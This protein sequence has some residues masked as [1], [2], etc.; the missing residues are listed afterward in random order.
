M[1]GDR[2]WQCRWARTNRIC[3]KAGDAIVADALAVDRFDAAAGKDDLPMNSAGE[4]A[5]TLTSGLAGLDMFQTGFISQWRSK[6][7]EA[8]L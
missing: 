3:Y 2:Q 1:Q 7:L 8:F 4:R 5:S 6:T